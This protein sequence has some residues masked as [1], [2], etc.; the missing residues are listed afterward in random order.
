L[1]ENVLATRKLSLVRPARPGMTR[2]KG[3][4]HQDEGAFLTYL[5]RRIDCEVGRWQRNEQSDGAIRA[6]I[7]RLA[8]CALKILKSSAE[9]DAW[10]EAA[11]REPETRQ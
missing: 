3:L 8:C 1:S 11:T 6:S 2:S 10:L 5:A 4:I 7:D 9:L